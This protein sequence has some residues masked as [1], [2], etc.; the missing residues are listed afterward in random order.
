MHSLRLNIH[1]LLTSQMSA[2]A[3]T[4]LLLNG[5]SSPL[6]SS[7]SCVRKGVQCTAINGAFFVTDARVHRTQRDVRTHHNCGL[8]ASTICTHRLTSSIRRSMPQ[9]MSCTQ[10][11]IRR[12]MLQMMSCSR[13]HLSRQSEMFLTGPS[14]FDTLSSSPLRTVSSSCLSCL[15][16]PMLGLCVPCKPCLV[17]S[18][19]WLC[20]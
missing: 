20:A 11:S 17:Y 2:V 5:R 14:F 8:V 19:P 9:V 10:A 12:P 13:V 15:L 16:Q 18:A 1:Y 3:P 7:V 6:D 4:V